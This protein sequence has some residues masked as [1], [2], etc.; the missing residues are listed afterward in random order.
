MGQEQCSTAV[1]DVAF[2]AFTRPEKDKTVIGL[3][4]FE[5]N[6]TFDNIATT[7][8]SV[9]IANRRYLNEMNNTM[10][11]RKLGCSN[12]FMVQL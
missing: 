4:L 10:L 9:Y 12:V 3:W 7:F 1:L 2:E 6:I 8:L 11:K 5:K